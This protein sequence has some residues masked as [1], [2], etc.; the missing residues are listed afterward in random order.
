L[1]TGLRSRFTEFVVDEISSPHDL[2]TL[3]GDY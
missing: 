1:P 2:A 3:I